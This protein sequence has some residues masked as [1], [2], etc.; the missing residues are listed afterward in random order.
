MKIISLYF[1][2]DETYLP[3]FKIITEFTIGSISGKFNFTCQHEFM[4]SNSYKK[5]I[6]EIELYCE[7]TKD[8]ISIKVNDY[9]ENIK[10]VIFWDNVFNNIRVV[11]DNDNKLG[12]EYI[13]R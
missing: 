11:F 2:G 10:N 8:Y 1:N 5:P 7:E 6:T 12:F 4:Y 3:S 13:Y 9:I